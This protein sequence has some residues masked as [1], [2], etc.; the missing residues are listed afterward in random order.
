MSRLSRRD[1][2]KLASALPGA[3]AL[4][5]LLPNRSWPASGQAPS[6]PNI[7]IF[8]F[9]AMSARNL[10][11]Y[12]YPRKTTP[13]IERF[14]QRATVYNA[15]S[16]A[17]SFTVPGT[18]SLLTGL[19]P[20][21]H[22]A[23]N[24]AGLIARNLLDRNIFRLVGEQYHRLAFAQ[25]LWPVY[26]FDQFQKDIDEIL[27]AGSFSQLDFVFGERF[28]NDPLNAQRVL[29][30]F[31]FSQGTA[32]KSLVF[33][34]AERIS[35]HRAVAHTNQGGY[36]N[37]LPQN[38]QYPLYFRLPAVF[39]GLMS[40]VESLGSA[41]L[42][43]FHL[44]PPHDPYNPSKK[45]FRTFDDGWSP[46]DKPMHP[47]GDHWSHKDLYRFRRAYDEYLAT[48]D[49]EF[50]RML[51]FLESHGVFE[52][53]YVVV[54]SDHGELFERGERGHV[55]PL[56]YEAGIRVPLII[57]SP[58]QKSRQDVNS[59]T[60]SV[61]VAPTLAH[62][63]GNPL[64]DW[65]EGELLPLLGGQELPERSIF[66]LYAL[67]NPAFAKLSRI[68]LAMRKGSYKML[69]YRGYYH[70][71]DKFELYDLQNDPEELHDLYSTGSAIAK[72]LQEEVLA[73]LEAVN[74]PYKS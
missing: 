13:N 53:S 5:R 67:K 70:S 27:P 40:T 55:S 21:T 56:L 24:D 6:R 14:A 69:F 52:T 72:S 25:N 58:G 32:P 49:E 10:S 48:L 51:D 47:L 62:L 54:T 35:L 26:F 3:L 37:G 23:I 15:H 63:A 60:S 66:T 43:Y 33:S 71:G 7:L 1:F 59:P 38:H 18:A 50:G 22:R 34:L 28:K 2:L 20:W 41:S 36:P 9:D 30:D 31:F 11:V 57:S 64:P 4:A 44:Y 8:V 65:R 45:Y 68:S 16:S 19:Y 17:G 74:A 46:V 29:D 61:D 42:A 73:K 39:D 12:G